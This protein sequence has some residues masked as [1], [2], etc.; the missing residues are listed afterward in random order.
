M[1]VPNEG[2]GGISKFSSSGAPISPAP[3]G[4][5]GG[6]VI[7]PSPVAIDPLSNVWVANESASSISKFS[8]AG[9]PITTSG[10]TGSGVYGPV[11]LVI[12]STGNVWVANTRTSGTISEFNSSGE[13]LSGSNGYISGNAG[14]NGFSDIAIDSSGNVWVAGQVLGEFIGLARPTTT[15]LVACLMK[16]SPAAVCLP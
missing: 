9:E 16:S 5:S 13:A 4:Y 3:F 15:P 14:S 7:N 12:D 10:I 2:D 6:G 11:A 1:W 8:S